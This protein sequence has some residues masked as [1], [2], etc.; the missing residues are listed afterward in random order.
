MTCSHECS[1]LL[2]ERILRQKNIDRA[3]LTL[4]EGIKEKDFEKIERTASFLGLITSSEVSRV[5]LFGDRCEQA[6]TPHT[7]SERTLRP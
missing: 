2:E 4:D 6:P 5:I 7:D 1:E 3:A